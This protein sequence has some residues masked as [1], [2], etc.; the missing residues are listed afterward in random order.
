MATFINN[1]TIFEFCQE[2]WKTKCPKGWWGGHEVLLCD[3]P[4]EAIWHRRC[5]NRTQESFQ[6]IL[7]MSNYSARQFEIP[8]FSL[9]DLLCV[10]PSSYRSLSCLYSVSLSLFLPLIYPPTLS[11]SLY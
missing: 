7:N 4:G 11:R 2:R 8:F 10:S 1:G 3:E 9:S 6:E 5:H